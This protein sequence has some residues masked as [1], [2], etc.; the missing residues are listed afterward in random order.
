MAILTIAEAARLIAAKKLSPVELTQAPSTASAA[1]IRQLHAFMLVTEERALADAK[2]AEARQMAGDAARPAAT[3]SRSRHKD[4][5]DTAG[6]RT[7][8]HSKLLQDNVP[9]ARRATVREVGRGRHGAARQARDARIR[10]R[11][12]VLRPALA[13]GAQPL[14]HRAFHRRLVLRH[15]RGGRRGPDPGR[16]RLRHRRL[17]PRPGGAVRH[18]RHQADLWPVQPRGRPAAGLHARPRRADGVDGGGLRAPAAGAW[19]ATIPT[20]RPAPTGRCRT[21]PP[22]SA[23]A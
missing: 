14:E 15:R 10:L 7:T 11:R 1:S 22:T 13:A 9:D 5:Y 20:T 2:A 23:R 18:R 3:A 21:S 4:I 12:A 17:D 6:I 19:P 8:A 16:H